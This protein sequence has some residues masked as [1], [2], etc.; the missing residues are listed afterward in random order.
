M[1]VVASPASAGPLPSGDRLFTAAQE[2]V[3]GPCRVDCGPEDLQPVVERLLGEGWRRGAG[4]PWAGVA[5]GVD[6][7]SGRLFATCSRR[8]SR[9]PPRL[10]VAWGA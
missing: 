9:G 10:W 1:V 4:L 7:G 3:Y 8:R 5:F 2:L 6:A